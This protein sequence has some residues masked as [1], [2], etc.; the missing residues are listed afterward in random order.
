[1]TD[2]CFGYEIGKDDLS[3]D[4]RDSAPDMP[5]CKVIDQSFDWKGDQLLKIPWKDT[6]I[7]ETHVR[8]MT[9]EHQEVRANCAVPTLGWPRTPCSN[10]SRSWAS[11]AV[12]LMPVH[13][14]WTAGTCS[15]KD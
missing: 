7:Y 14:S 2:A 1:M 10:T 13:A 5:K 15:I 11:P 6:I 9:I 12:E 4:Q 8:G 3:F